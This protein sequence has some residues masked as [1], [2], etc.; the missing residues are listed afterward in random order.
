MAT[1]DPISFPDP[2]RSEL[3]STIEQLVAQAQRVLAT[4]GRLRSLLRANRL[5]V[6]ELELTEVLRRIVE[7][8]LDLVDAKFGA[9]GVIG[10]D[11]RLEQFIHVG[12]SAE[13]A[14]A[15]GDLP[16]GDGILGAVIDAAMP[17]RLEHL[18]DDPRA[19]GFPPH[20]PPMEGF[21]GVPIRVRGEIYGNLY[22]TSPTAGAF[23][24]ED[25]ELVGVLAATAGIAIENA[26][27]FA[28]SVR[29]EKW[30]AALTDVSAA[31]LS[32]EAD[33]LAVVVEHVA[34]LVD[35]E[36]VTV[37]VESGTPNVLSV[38]AARGRGSSEIQDHL[39][40]AEGTLV[41]RALVSGAPVLA[42][43]QEPDE[44][45]D[46]Q[47]A[48]GPTF[49]LPLAASGH[50]IGALSV[51][52][53][54]GAIP[55]STTDLAMA[56]EFGAQ[57][58]VALEV[59]RGRADRQQ[60][61]LFDDR[62]RIARDLHDHVIQRLFGAGLSLQSVAGRVPE[63]LQ[64]SIRAQ[65]DVI[66]AAISEIR[67]VV[68]ALSA[69]APGAENSLRHRLLDIVSEAG[70]NMTAPPRLAFSG[71]VDLLIR[72]P[73]AD[74]VTA[75]VRESLTN[76]ARHAEAAN[77]EV[78][79]TVDDDEL[80]VRVH[81]DGVGFSPGSRSSGTANLAARAENLGGSYSIDGGA[82]TGTSVLWRVPASAW[83]S[84]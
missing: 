20:H 27:L 68:F 37:V 72:G 73:L 47:A 10:P 44:M 22:L 39:Y 42:E 13:I 35:A 5:V 58:S 41:G 66:D 57:A 45:V 70:S 21:L 3:E 2:A 79:V 63:V 61:E 56:T 12:I 14:A 53:A 31:L 77:C 46:G 84:A 40:R 51:S 82:E 1:S 32:G 71:P 6:E 38:A 8:A 52:R 24:S 26:R 48:F 28:A 65:V 9:L 33:T 54:V 49:V 74:D 15:I 59:A 25:E 17:I 76:V 16:R 34:A 43:G 80:R 83:G 75:V 60:L 62:T 64:D 18:G 30:G 11:G 50:S 23:S 7:A 4:Q 67:T 81:D 19:V 55:F 78:D 29:R 36:L 69:P